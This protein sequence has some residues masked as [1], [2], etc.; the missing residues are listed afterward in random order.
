MMSSLICSIRS[1]L[2]LGSESATAEIRRIISNINLYMP[3][4]AVICGKRFSSSNLDRRL[5]F[6]SMDGHSRNHVN[7]LKGLSSGSHC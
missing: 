6:R 1:K 5:Q 4:A 3:F 2:A 7:I